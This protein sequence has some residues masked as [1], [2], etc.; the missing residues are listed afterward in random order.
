MSDTEIYR[1]KKARPQPS[2]A[3]QSIIITQLR[4]A[5]WEHKGKLLDCAKPDKKDFPGEI[6]FEIIPDE[7]NVQT[8][9]Y[10]PLLTEAS[11][12]HGHRSVRQHEMLGEL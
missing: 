11:T 10:L 2:G 9:G 3:T 6:T 12:Q 5:L 4:K 7:F 8:K 1:W